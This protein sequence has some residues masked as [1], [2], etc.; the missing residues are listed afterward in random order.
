MAGH[1]HTDIER[2]LEPINTGLERV[3]QSTSLPPQHTASILRILTLTA[4][5]RT[6]ALENGGLDEECENKLR[7]ALAVLGDLQ[8]TSITI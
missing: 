4:G 5:I 1:L 6:R 3:L 7:E 2:A 8:T